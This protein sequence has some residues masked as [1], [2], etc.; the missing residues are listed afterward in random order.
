MNASCNCVDL[1]RSVQ[2]MCSEQG[3]TVAVKGSA[4]E[5]DVGWIYL[6]YRVLCHDARRPTLIAKE[7][8]MIAMQLRRP[9]SSTL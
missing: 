6:G 4:S 3:L 2:F 1:F 8:W 9:I 7:K 5:M